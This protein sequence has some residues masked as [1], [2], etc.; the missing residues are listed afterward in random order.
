MIRFLILCIALLANVSL[1]QDAASAQKA[2]RELSGA[3]K[4]G[5][6]MWMVEKMY[7]NMKK[8]LA[9]RLPGGMEQLET[10]YRK[11]GEEIK[12]P[13][14]RIESYEV[15]APAGE[16]PVKAGTEMLVVL[17][18]RMVV[19]MKNPQNGQLVRIEQRSFLYA[20]A[21]KG[22]HPTWFF[23]D[24]SSLSMNELRSYIYDIPLNI[25]LPPVS[26]KVLR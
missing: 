20:I 14:I 24:G 7:P 2:A 17:P 18:I 19:S 3:V 16:Y 25:P 23:I 1:A 21:Q 5:D 13:G 11:M 15:M 26:K 8:S 22:D 4:T 10:T 9:R 12:K 6:M